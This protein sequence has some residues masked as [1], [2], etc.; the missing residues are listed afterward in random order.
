MLA[1]ATWDFP[2]LNRRLD[3]VF[4]GDVGFIFQNKLFDLFFEGLGFF[5]SETYLTLPFS[6]P[7][8]RP[9]ERLRSKV[10]REK[11][12][13]IKPE[14]FCGIDRFAQMTMIGL[15]DRGATGYRYGWGMMMHGGDAF[16]DKLIGA[17]NASNGVVN[18]LGAIKRD[19]D[20]VKE[21]RNLLC[22][23]I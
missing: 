12:D 1:K 14:S 17:V 6:W 19:N 15:L 4:V 11:R 18:I 8:K 9:V 7:Q 2:K 22:A 10:G 5:E 3:D 16:V 13:G 23:F 20:V 21:S